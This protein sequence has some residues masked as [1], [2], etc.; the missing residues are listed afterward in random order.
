MTSSAVRHAERHAVRHC[1]VVS[2]YALV[3]CG[4]VCASGSRLRLP[5]RTGT[6][7]PNLADNRNVTSFRAGPLAAA[8]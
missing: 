4:I 5:R 6:L 7:Y 3:G 2:L 8:S 1:H